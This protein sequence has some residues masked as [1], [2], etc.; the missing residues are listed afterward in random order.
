MKPNSIL[1]ALT[2]GSHRL[3]LAES[4]TG[5]MVCA[6]L[7]QIPGISQRLCGSSVTYRAETKN[8]WL[9]IPETL[10]EQYTPE[11]PEV[12]QAMCRAVLQKTPEATL[13]AAITGHLGPDAPAEKDGVVYISVARRVDNQILQVTCLR[14]RLTK[15]DRVA[16]QIEASQLVIKQLLSSMSPAQ[17][18]G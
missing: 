18:G 4:C 8:S 14:R 10:I 5:G 15:A 6:I 2:E 1:T 16:R 13:A 12:T 17:K 7:S 9:E 11:S 3:V